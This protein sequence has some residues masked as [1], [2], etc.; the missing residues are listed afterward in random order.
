MAAKYGNPREVY[1]D[2]KQKGGIKRSLDHFE[3]AVSGGDSL[4]LVDRSEFYGVY[5]L[6]LANASVLDRVAEKRK[7]TNPGGVVKDSLVEAVVSGKESASDGNEDIID[8]VTG[9]EVKKPGTETR[10]GNIVVPSPAGG[11]QPTPET[12]AKK[13]NK[14]EKKGSGSGIEL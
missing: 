9:H 7:V 1:K 14:P 12:K 6:I 5:C 8:R 11:G 4:K 10:H 3:W 13:D 2:E